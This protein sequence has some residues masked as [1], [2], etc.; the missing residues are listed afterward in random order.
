M[1]EPP[2]KKLHKRLILHFFKESP[3]VTMNRC[4]L[5]TILT[6]WCQG[7]DK[8]SL[9]DSETL[10]AANEKDDSPSQSDSKLLTVSSQH[11]THHLMPP[12][13]VLNPLVLLQLHLV[14]Q[15]SYQ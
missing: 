4:L 1:A 12:R 5:P 8:D 9:T 11:W 7:A 2:E 10:S 3:L 15:V 6:A 14:S 13:H